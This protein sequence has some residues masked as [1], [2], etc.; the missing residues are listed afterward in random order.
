MGA[1][2]VEEPAAM[3]P[4]GSSGKLASDAAFLDSILVALRQAGTPAASLTV[5]PSHLKGGYICQ[6]FRIHLS[7]ESAADAAAH[8]ATAVLKQSAPSDSGGDHL[9]ALRLKL[10]DREW[11]FYESGLSEAVPVRTPRYLGS[12]RGEDGATV[13]VLLEDLCV[14]G[15]VLNPTLDEAGVLLTARH[16]A[17]LHARYWNAPEL[18][19]GALGIRPHDDAWFS[20]SWQEAVQGYWPRFEHVWRTGEGGNRAALPEEAYAA[21]AAIV[22]AFGWVQSEVSAQP[23]TFIHGDI[24]PGNMFLMPDG[25]PA[26]IDWQ[27]T[28]VGKGVQDLAF[29]LIEGYDIPTCKQLEPKVKAAYLQALRD[30]GVAG[31]TEEQLERDWQLATLHFP[32]YVAMWFGTTADADLVDPDFPR[33]FV[34]RAFDAILRHGAHKLLP[35]A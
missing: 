7:Y 11:Q 28:A 3:A 15:A 4:S 23:H 9:V 22:R 16:A 5:D 6:T 34:P 33:R 20:P 12:L 18:G 30:E 26:F 14:P 17:K 27:Y 31:Y 32:F 24:K 21:G 29:M 2:L 35:G 10:Y 13:G 25:T 8:P 1:A 19:S